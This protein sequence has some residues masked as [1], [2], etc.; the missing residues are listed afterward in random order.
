MDRVNLLL[1]L[2]A[3]ALSA[4]TAIAVDRS[5]TRRRLQPP[6]FSVPWRRGL[7]A[8]LV[9]ALLWVGIFGPAAAV[10]E[11]EPPPDPTGMPTAGL[12][13]LHVLMAL[14]LLG[15]FALGWWGVGV[16][17]VSWPAAPPGAAGPQ[18]AGAGGDA[19]EGGS[20][21]PSSEGVPGAASG[22]AAP[23]P[24]L[25][26]AADGGGEPPALAPGALR[27][28]L[29]GPGSWW[30]TVAAQLGLVAARPEEE[31]ALGLA[32]GA[33]GWFGVIAVMVAAVGLYALFAGER[34]LPTQAPEMIAWIAGL[35]VAVRV[36]VSLSAGLVE[37][38]FF[39]GFLQPRVGIAFST[40][41]FV[42]AHAS[43]EQPFMLVGLT[44]LSLLLAGLVRW[45]QNIWPAVVAHA[46]FDL[47]QLLVVIPLAL[48]F[49][50]V[51]AP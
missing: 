10:G 23:G 34:A 14:V 13:I 31:V 20:I 15:W 11:G 21:P 8:A 50:P 38:A 45:R 46:A 32:G 3:L 44:F 40:F 1:Q 29:P 26:P 48:K 27:P 7:A 28:R 9:A 36:A 30:R 19:G 17:R 49:L 51:A 47:V 22:D 6:G 41:L 4:A 25:P 42:L 5:T 2:S 33:A 35:P 43:Y 18:A 39:R 37:E 12:F 24:G 16:H